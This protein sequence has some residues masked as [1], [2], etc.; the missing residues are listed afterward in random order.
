[1]LN[2]LAFGISLKV[3]RDIKVAA[4]ELPEFSAVTDRMRATLDASNITAQ[5]VAVLMVVGMVIAALLIRE[6]RQK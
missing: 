4:K 5:T 3:P 6:Q 2:D 1:M